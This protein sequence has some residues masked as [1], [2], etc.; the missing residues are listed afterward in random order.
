MAEWSI[1]AVL[2][3]V[4]LRGSGG[5]NPSLSAKPTKQKMSE[6][7]SFLFCRTCGNLFT[8]ESYKTKSS[9][10]LNFCFV[11]FARASAASGRERR[12]GARQRVVA[13]PSQ[14][15]S[16]TACWRGRCRLVICIDLIQTCVCLR[17]RRSCCWFLVAGQ[18]FS[19]NKCYICRNNHTKNYKSQYNYGF[20]HYRSP[21][22]ATQI[23]HH[24]Q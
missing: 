6:M 21:I 19:E 3:T 18:G 9:W 17:L 23:E 11:W 24:A 2:K 14:L 22:G 12:H 16:S 8:E 20:T 7:T 5:S 4:E 15:L 13:N 1:A 10:L